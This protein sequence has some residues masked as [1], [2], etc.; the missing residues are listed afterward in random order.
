[1]RGI[2][3]RTSDLPFT[4]LHNYENVLVVL[5]IS[6]LIGLSAEDV[7]QELKSYTFLSHRLQLVRARR[8]KI[9]R[10]F[11]KQLMHMLSVQP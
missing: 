7:F 6:Q 2:E 1:M 3:F 4:G 8:S 5:L 11:K 10:R 9:L